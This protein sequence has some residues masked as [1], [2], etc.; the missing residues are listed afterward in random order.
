MKAI[1]RRA[2]NRW[3]MWRIDRRLYRAHPQLR[4]RHAAIKAARRAHKPTKQI[5]NEQQQDMLRLLRENM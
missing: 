1:I 4:E 2:I 3:V 5:I